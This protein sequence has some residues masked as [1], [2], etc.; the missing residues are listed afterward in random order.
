MRHS[1]SKSQY[2]ST[3]ESIIYFT[4][5]YL[6]TLAALVKITSL[7][8]DIYLTSKIFIHEIMRYFHGISLYLLFC[9]VYEDSIRFFHIHVIHPDCAVTKV[10]Y[11]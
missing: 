4:Y 7:N 2:N 9:L 5:K 6:V 10:D 3:F 1:H 8:K 11:N